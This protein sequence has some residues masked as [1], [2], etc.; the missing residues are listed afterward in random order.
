MSDDEPKIMKEAF[1]EAIKEWI[2]DQVKILGWW[3][4]KMIAGLGL[5]ALVWIILMSNGWHK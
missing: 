2:E 3:G 5:F 1:K 4:V